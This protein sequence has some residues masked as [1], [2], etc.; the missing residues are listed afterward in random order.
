MPVAPS[1]I[2]MTVN[3]KNKTYDLAGGETINV[4]KSPA[5]TSLSVELLLPATRYGWARY[6]GAFRSPT[7]YLDNFEQLIS[8]KKPFQFVVIRM[9][10]GRR[11]WST[12]IRMALEK[13]TIKDTTNQGSDVLV[14]LS[15]KQYQPYG[16]KS[17]TFDTQGNLQTNSS[18][19]PSAAEPLTKVTAQPLDTL[20]TVIKRTFGVVTDAALKHLAEKNNVTA[21]ETLAPGREIKL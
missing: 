2:S 16:T 8:G 6:D 17:I 14:S 20:W 13:Y 21:T 19:R 10:G 3:G 12:D 11:L 9:Q 4:L 1:E 7:Y 5:L 18:S 15:M